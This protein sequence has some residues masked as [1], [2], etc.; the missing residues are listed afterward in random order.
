VEI[1]VRDTGAGIPASELPRIF[2][3][4]YQV[5]KVRGPGRG[6]GLGLAIVS[7]IV[8]AHGGRI[9]VTSA[10]ENQGAAF[11]VW[12]PALPGPAPA[13]KR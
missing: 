5:D 1:A 4:F 3:R 7:E 6:S 11:I 2:E 9:R 8:H 10:G 12:L 13:R